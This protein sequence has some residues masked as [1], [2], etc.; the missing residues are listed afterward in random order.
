[1]TQHKNLLLVLLLLGSYATAQQKLNILWITIE[2]T[3]QQFIGCYGNKDAR[4][5][6]IDKLASDG[7]RFNNAFSCGTVPSASR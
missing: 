7:V 2:D 4:T 3:S 5:P 1:M 6:V